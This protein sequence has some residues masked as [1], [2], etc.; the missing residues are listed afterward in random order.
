MAFFSTRCFSSGESATDSAPVICCATSLCTSKMSVSWR[1]KV[2]PQRCFSVLGSTRCTTIRTRCPARRTLPSSTAPTP[3]SSAIAVIFLVVFLYCMEDVRE[4][5]LSALT[6][7]S[8]AM[9]S[10]VI[11]SLKYSFSGSVLMFSNGSTATD[12]RGDGDLLTIA[13]A[14]PTAMATVAGVPSASANWRGGA[15]PVGGHA[16]PSPSAPRRP[17]PR[18]RARGRRAAE[19]TGEV[20]RLAMT[21]VRVE[22][23]NGGSPTSISNR[24]QPRL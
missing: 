5:T 21:A 13:W 6:F 9:M 4:I 20:S 16:S 7:E 15:E 24:T 8:W 10:S 14:A 3:S 23:R 18:A 11:P 19:G 1:S 17:P 2:S 12:L 22:P